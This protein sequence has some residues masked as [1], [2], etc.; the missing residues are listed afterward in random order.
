MV[1]WQP[2]VATHCSIAL[3]A[4]ER[5]AEGGE[6]WVACEGRVVAAA[7]RR[8]ALQQRVDGLAP[9]SAHKFRVRATAAPPAQHLEAL[10]AESGC[11]GV[12]AMRPPRDVSRRAANR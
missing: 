1:S 3:H 2:A 11:V 12:W 5:R 9:G 6:A 4:L 10:S 7:G 8:W